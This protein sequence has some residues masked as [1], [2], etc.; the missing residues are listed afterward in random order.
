MKFTHK[1]N[2]ISVK[3]ETESESPTSLK[4]PSVD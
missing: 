1:I 3:R 4:S 2:I